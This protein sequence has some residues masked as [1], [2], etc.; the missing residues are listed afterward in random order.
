MRHSREEGHDHAEGYPAGEADSGGLG[1]PGVAW[2]G[3]WR[4]GRREDLYFVPVQRL[5]LRETQWRNLAF[6]GPD[7]CEVVM[8]V[9]SLGE[10]S[11]TMLDVHFA[12]YVVW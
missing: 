9:R 12:G 7:M 2:Y 3:Q 4:S 1:G 5:V 8:L 10:E 6:W 11:D